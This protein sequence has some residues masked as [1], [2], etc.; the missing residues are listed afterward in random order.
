[1]LSLR[2]LGLLG[3]VVITGCS[4][5][6]RPDSSPKSSGTD[7]RTN[8][9]VALTFDDGPGPYTNQLLDYLSAYNAKA[10][11]YLVGSRVV[12]NTAVV[13][14]MAREGHEIGNHSWNHADLTTLS[15]QDIRAQII[16]TNESIRL[17][18]R[19]EVYPASFRPPY[20]AYNKR[21]ITGTGYNPVMWDVDTLDWYYRNPERIVKLAL[22]AKAGDIILLHDIHPTTVQSVPEI[23]RQLTAKGFVFVTVGELR[24]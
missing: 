12:Q 7:C 21:V 6:T 10:T 19:N 17:A 23:L 8:Q 9:C 14:R 24:R 11:F 20:G 13:S 15:E 22:T 4:V 2:I 16:R 5:A 1:M 18:T 3:L